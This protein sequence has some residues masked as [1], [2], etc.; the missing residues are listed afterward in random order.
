M[1][2]H[3]TSPETAIDPSHAEALLSDLAAELVRL[4]FEGRTRA[5]HLRALELKRRIGL[6]G[7]SL[8]TDD[9]LRATHAKIVALRSETEQWCTLLRLA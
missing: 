5:L 4:P 8:P 3:L 2:S 9:E 6:W 1:I 7:S